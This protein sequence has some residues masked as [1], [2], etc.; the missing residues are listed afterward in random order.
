MD[1]KTMMINDLKVRLEVLIPED[2]SR[3]GKVEFAQFRLDHI[4]AVLDEVER[5][6]AERETFKTALEKIEDANCFDE[7]VNDL[8][9]QTMAREALAEAVL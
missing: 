7:S 9:L 3:S 4:R 8:E 2:I 1:Q 6:T 5:L